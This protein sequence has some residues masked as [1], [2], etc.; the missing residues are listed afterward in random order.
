MR[1][2]CPIRRPSAS[3]GSARKTVA[4]LCKRAAGKGGLDRR[5]PSTSFSGCCRTT[6]ASGLM[7]SRRRTSSMACGVGPCTSGTYRSSPRYV[8]ALRPRDLQSVPEPWLH[9][10]ASSPASALRRSALTMYPVAFPHTRTP[11]TA[12]RH[13]PSL[14]HRRPSRISS[15]RSLSRRASWASSRWLCRGR[16][17]RAS[18]CRSRSRTYRFSWC[19]KS[20]KMRAGAS[21]RRKLWSLRKRCTSSSYVPSLPGPSTSRR[22]QR[23][24]GAT[25]H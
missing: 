23:T 4:W 2:G 13:P 3:S 12:F 6:S 22:T 21:T 15:Y 8:R 10:S 11:V 1:G 17:C 24:R 16:R 18:R 25:P 14:P 19:H 5:W 7:A 20:N 9:P